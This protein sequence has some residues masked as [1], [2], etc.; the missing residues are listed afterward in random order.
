MKRHNEGKEVAVQ[1]SLRP[2]SWKEMRA[3]AEQASLCTCKSVG[4]AAEIR[5]CG[6][7][8]GA[9]TVLFYRNQPKLQIVC[10]ACRHVIQSFALQVE[11]L[12]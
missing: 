12:S 3:V 5:V 7:C 9:L 1:G 10:D 2:L 8:G 4:C 6:T 11:A